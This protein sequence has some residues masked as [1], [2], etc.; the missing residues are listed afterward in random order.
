[1]L[2][3]DLAYVKKMI[4][5]WLETNKAIHSIL[6]HPAHGN[7]MGCNF[8]M[9]NTRVRKRCPDK[10]IDMNDFLPDFAKLATRSTVAGPTHFSG[11]NFD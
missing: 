5:E 4:D 1:M 6:D 8:G 3:L 7:L 11:P 10:I 9:N 2:I